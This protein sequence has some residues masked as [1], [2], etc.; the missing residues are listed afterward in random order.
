MVPGALPVRR[1]EHRPSQDVVEEGWPFTL[2]PVRQLLRDGL[3]LGPGVTFLVGENGSGKSTLVEA[4]AMAY[5]LGAEGGSSGSLHATRPSESPLHRVLRLV[6]EPGAAR[7]GYFVRAET[8]HGLYTYLEENPGVRDPRFHELSHGEGFLALFGSRMDTRGFYVLDEPESA[9]S[10]TSC[11]ALAGQLAEHAAAGSQV[12]CATHSP[13]L[14]A[15]PGARVLELSED[16][17]AEVAWQDLALV[18]HWR[19]YLADPRAY[20]RH[21]LPEGAA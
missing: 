15:L 10:F 21:L 19:R 8:A 1:V 17:F 2:A 20:L 9:L 6:R 16:G 12:L 7:W 5:G 13:L 11:L 18:D 3:D 14:T 4:V